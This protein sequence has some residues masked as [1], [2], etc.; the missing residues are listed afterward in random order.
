MIYLFIFLS[1]NH[2]LE[3]MN[4]N[5][6]VEN[7]NMANPCTSDWIAMKFHKIENLR[8]NQK[9]NSF[10][11]YWL[12]ARFVLDADLI[13]ECT[14]DLQSVCVA[15][16]LKIYTESNDEDALV[17]LIDAEFEYYRIRYIP[18]SIEAGSLF[19]SANYK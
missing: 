3:N 18:N 4:S 11:L 6:I 10:Q 17:Y 19:I 5:I 12:G 15:D 13:L 8:A 9:L 7:H 16:K 1:I 2:I 14:N